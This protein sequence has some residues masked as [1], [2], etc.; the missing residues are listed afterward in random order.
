ML[1][2]IERELLSSE[3]LKLR[4]RT[5][6][7]YSRGKRPLLTSALVIPDMTRPRLADPTAA[8]LD[9]VLRLRPVPEPTRL[10]LL[11]LEVLVD[12]EEVLDL[13]PELRR[14]VVDVRDRAP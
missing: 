9:D 3:L 10:G 13:V 11:A 1:L 4:D 14:D 7:H 2:G 5:K 12:L 6:T 8:R